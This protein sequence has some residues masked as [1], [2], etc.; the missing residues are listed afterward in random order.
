MITLK[1]IAKEAGVSVMTV[2]RVINGHASKVSRETA[3]K[4]NSIIKRSGYVPN[5]SARSLSS[6]TSHIVSIIMRG[7]GN[8]LAESYNSI[9]FANIVH[10]V[11]LQDYYTM[12]HFINDYRDITNRLRTWS[13]DGAIFLGPFD[14]DIM[15]IK[16]DNQIPLVFI[17]SYSPVRQLTNVGIDDY[18][19]GVLAAKH[20]IERGH[21]SFAFIGT[22][23]DSSSV[24]Q[25]RLKGFKDSIEEAGLTFN[26]EHILDINDNISLTKRIL[27]F[28]EPVTAIFATSDMIAVDLINEMT[29]VG[30]R[31]PEDYSIIGFDDLPISHYITPK[32]TTIAQDINRKAQLASDILFRHIDDYN[33]PSQNIILDVHL[34]ER[35]S[36][37][38]YF[39]H[40]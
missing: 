11:Q 26:P 36:V 28:K 8:S 20:F 9:M 13:I 17:D 15:N 32:L 33:A 18:K 21:R 30:L 35:D 31:V 34:I 22:S 3:E 29:A 39:N 40:S 12:V 7:E 38:T 27:N 16:E 19:G 5:S 24:V 4:I 2:S 1:D 14:K 6:K 10:H 25:H 37:L 23:L